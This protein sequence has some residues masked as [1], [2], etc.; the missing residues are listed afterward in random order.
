MTAL[1]VDMALSTVSGDKAPFST[2]VECFE[3]FLHVKL[4]KATEVKRTIFDRQYTLTS[5]LEALAAKVN[6][7]KNPK[8]K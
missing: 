6:Q 7:A 2:I 5:Y 4:G 1:D 8:Q 3:Q